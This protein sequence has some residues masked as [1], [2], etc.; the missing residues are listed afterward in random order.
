M[1][2][3][4]LGERMKIFYEAVPKTR[5]MRRC[6]VII[7]LDGKAAHTFTHGFEKPF[8][9]IFTMTMQ[10]TMK[11]LCK[12]IQGC[13]LGYTQSDEITLVLIDYN[14]LETQAFFDYEIQKLCSITASMATLYFNHFFQESANNLKGYPLY[15]LYCKKAQAGLM[16]DSRCFNIPKEEVCNMLY[17]RQLDA[18]KN[19]I[20]M[21]GRANFSHKQ[22]QNKSCEEIKQMLHEKEDAKDWENY[23]TFYQRGSCCVKQEEGWEIDFEPPI[24]SQN[25][26]YVNSR[27]LWEEK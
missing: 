6:P 11:H 27:I 10:Q 26:D 15:D 7:R 21:V 1:N 19:S 8:D 5:L 3:D 18:M 24:F 22:L 13:V 23:S 25:R 14:T 9:V 20:Q 16:F 17:W 4:N 12:N 2:R